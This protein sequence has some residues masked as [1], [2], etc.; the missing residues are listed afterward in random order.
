MNSIGLDSRTG[1]TRDE[2][3][4]RLPDGAVSDARTAPPEAEADT[5]TVIEDRLGQSKLFDLG[6][7]D[8]QW[9]PELGTLW[10]FITP[11]DR[12]NYNLGLLRDTMAWQMEAKK[13]FAAGEGDLKYMVLGSRFPG[14]FNL[15]GDLEMFARCIENQDRETLRQYSHLCVDIVDRVW[16][17]NDMPVVNIGLAQGDALGG[18]FEALM[19]FDVIIAERQARFGLPE[20]LFGLFPGMGAYSILAR[21]LGHAVAERMILSGKVYTA[22]EMHEMGVITVLADAGRGEEVARDYIQSNIGRHAGH[23]GVYRAGRRVESLDLSELRD[24]V[25]GWVDT[26]M[27]LTD[28]DL[29]MMR[30]LAAAQTRLHR[31]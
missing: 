22:E 23:V 2:A 11:L 6:Q 12:P 28:K 15:G 4:A 27:K 13:V 18:G 21:K 9:E 29:K 1:E 5:E 10:A 7:I 30:R 17:C 16:H 3:A 20:V 19:C 25:D 8:V 14:V 24:I 31:R 26:A